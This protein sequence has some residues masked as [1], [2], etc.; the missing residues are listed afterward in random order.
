MGRNTFVWR[1]TGSDTFSCKPQGRVV[2][3]RGTLVSLHTE[4]MSNLRKMFAFGGIALLGISTLFFLGTL[5]GVFDLQSLEVAGQTGIRTL[6]GV[7]VTG[8]LLAAIG[9]YDG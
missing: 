8:C 2:G 4:R 7:A 3:L 5:F 1:V 6:A 9:F